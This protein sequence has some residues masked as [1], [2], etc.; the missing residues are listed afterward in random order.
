MSAAWRSTKPR[1]SRAFVRSALSAM[2]EIRA[3]F[4]K[5]VRPAKGAAVLTDG[6]ERGKGGPPPRPRLLAGRIVD[7]H[8]AHAPSTAFG[9]P[10]PP[11][12]RGGT[13]GIGAR[14]P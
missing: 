9:G 7:P 8:S 2:V 1:G 3:L 12:R 13:G 6:R 5:M 4:E 10:P 11:L 14:A